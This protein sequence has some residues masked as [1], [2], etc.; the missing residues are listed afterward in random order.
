[1][2]R[3]LSLALLTACAHAPP[4]PSADVAACV[5]PR[6][7]LALVSDL[8]GP[9]VAGETNGVLTV[10][11]HGCGDA[12]LS[13]AAAERLSVGIVGTTSAAVALV[14]LSNDPRA[15]C[16]TD[17]VAGMVADLGKTLPDA[18]ANGGPVRV[19]WSAPECGR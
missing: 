19:E 9:L 17:Y 12:V 6:V 13:Q 18:L 14:A 10:D 5:V 8:V 1:M 2:T 15:A 3:A 7:A 16:W 4:Q 11:A